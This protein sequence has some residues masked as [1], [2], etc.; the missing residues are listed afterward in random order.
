MTDAELVARLAADDREALAELFETHAE[1]VYNHCFRRTASWD[2]AEDA[3]STVFLEVWRGRRRVRLHDDSAL[4]WL[5]GVATNVCR[6]L[7][8]SARRQE[9]VAARLHVV[10]EHDPTDRVDDALD[11]ERRMADVLAAIRELPGTSR[12]CWHWSPGPAC[13]TTR[14]RPLS[15]YPSAPCDRELS[16]ART[17]LAAIEARTS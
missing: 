6:N 11:S 1:R 5:L 14:R 2:L 7:M 8:R 10:D 13:R 3:T 15:G 9:R 4:P 16:R 17:H 12:R